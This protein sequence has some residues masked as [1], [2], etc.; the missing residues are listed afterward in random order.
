MNGLEINNTCPH[1]AVA[2]YIVKCR[3]HSS[4]KLIREK[5]PFVNPITFSEITEAL[6][7]E[8]F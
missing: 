2:I 8:K 5:V 3:D 1:N 4:I 6:L 7:K